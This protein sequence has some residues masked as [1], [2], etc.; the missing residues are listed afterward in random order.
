MTYPH[1]LLLDG[2]KVTGLPWLDGF[3]NARRPSPESCTLAD[4]CP[5]P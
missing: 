2:G 4:P 1:V 5:S 3:V